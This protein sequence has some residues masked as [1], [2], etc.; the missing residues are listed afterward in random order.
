MKKFGFGKKGGDEG[1]DANRSA[2]FGRKSKSPAPGND[3][4]YA[5]APAGGDPYAQDANK[6]AGMTPYQRARAGVPINGDAPGGLPGGPR[7]GGGYGA[8]P[9]PAG[10]YGN[11][12]YGA[13]GGYGANRYDDNQN[14]YGANQRSGANGGARG[15]GGYGGLGR[16]NSDSTDAV[17]DELFSG[18]QN[19]Y[20][21]NKPPAE[22]YGQS[23]PS[24]ADGGYGGYG[25]TRELTAE[26]QE[27]EEY[28]A[29]KAQIKDVRNQS[30]QTTQ[31][32]R[33]NAS[34][35]EDIANASLAKLA[36]QGE[37]LHNTERNM[38]IAANHNK[39]AEEGAKE[40]KTANGSMFAVHIANPFTSKKRAAERDAA[41][42]DRHRQ[43]R[44]VREATRHE[45]FKS[46]Q[47]M[48]DTFREMSLSGRP[49][50]GAE[51]QS[52]PAGKSQ[53][54][55][56][57]DSSDEEAAAQ[58]REEER[59]IDENIR[60]LGGSTGRIQLAARALGREI[61][62]QTVLID[63]IAKKSDAVDDGVRMNRERLN[64]IR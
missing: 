22:G 63:N 46:N 49:Q 38:D 23:T 25:A 40:L 48:E 54:E 55:L 57:D 39:K 56:D 34:N 6:Y 53:F 43:E 21:Q 28:R 50:K 64:R 4:P 3:N 2:L 42:L 11:E 30:L 35:I 31:R 51:Q 58:A 12:K 27:A 47:R 26:E 62:S 17:R 37:R 24:G 32:M 60:A 7:A 14:A 41:I 19:R 15:P 9:Q 1:D 29:T 44:E 20:Q 5:Q 18:A 8:P 45:A 16:T 36:A 52:K 33:Q 61:D 59:M 10:G 13:A